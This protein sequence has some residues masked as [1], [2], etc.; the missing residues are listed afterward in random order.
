MHQS[1]N[2]TRLNKRRRGGT[3]LIVVG[4]L[5]LL[6]VG[7]SALFYMNGSDE[8][9]GEGAGRVADLFRVAE[10]DFNITLP[11][12][13]E[14]AALNQVE[15]RSPIE[16][17]AVITYIVSEGALIKKDELILEFATEQLR[18]D[19]KDA[20]LDALT[21]QNDYDAANNAVSIQ[22]SE[23][24]SLLSQ[25]M[26]DV[27]LAELAL[28]QWD[29][30]DRVSATQ[31]LDLAVETTRQNR[32]R[33]RDKYEKSKV[34]AE[35]GFISQ[36]ELKQDEIELIELEA[37]LAIAELD[38][39]T[40]LQYQVQIERAENES[41]VD[42]AKEELERVK[43]QNQAELQSRQG[44]LVTADD[45]LDIR[46]ER[47][48]EMTRQL[49]LSKVYA[50]QDGMVVYASS[51]P[52]SGWRG[53]SDEPPQI[54]SEVRQN[55]IIMILPDVSQMIASVMVHES[56][57]G[58][59]KPGQRATIVAD[60]LN[61]RPVRG[62]V[63]NVGVLAQTGN[64]WRDPN[65]RDYRVKILL[66]DVSDLGLKPSMRCKAEI[67]LDRVE[68]AIYVPMQAVQHAGSVSYVYVR[69]GSGYAQRQV[70]IGR[71]SEINWEILEGLEPGERVLL[72]D[73][74]PAEIISKL[75]IPTVPADGIG[76]DEEVDGA[77][78]TGEAQAPTP[79]GQADGPGGS[80]EPRPSESGFGGPGGGGNRGPMDPA[81]MISRFDQN[82]DGLLQ[83]EEIPEQM[84]DFFDRMDGN[85]DGSVD[86]AELQAMA[87]MRGDEDGDDEAGGDREGG[88]GD[89]RGGEGQGGRDGENQ[90]G[91]ESQGETTG[92][93]TAP[94]ETPGAG[95]SGR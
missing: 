18:N 72:R 47:R 19:L 36:D 41:A 60:A 9:S 16:G 77:A 80:D 54:G 6:T 1:H 3:T 66:E 21:G 56:L 31:T 25:A 94:A 29:Q 55:D 67:L 30:G 53:D 90:S 27:T 8:E 65:R 57:S 48:D 2:Q 43:Q 38:L 58:R 26:V 12:N 46:V 13:G 85:A 51:L 42:R 14:L 78:G 24:A 74:D 95:A 33:V 89:D 11:A 91:A 81:A 76:A 92:G 7:L 37:N 45:Q 32:D 61:T 4:G 63:L 71:S 15:I 73:P 23:N 82:S 50:Q 10:G 93:E 59:V 83:R 17:S 68:D 62:S 39:E 52:G 70:T 34:L 86:A 49:S 84:R 5:A 88:R 28:E 35:K 87:A 20:E 75:D 44:D 69:E 22:E 79:G 40:Y 64:N